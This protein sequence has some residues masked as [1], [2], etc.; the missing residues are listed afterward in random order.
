MERWLASSADEV[1]IGGVDAPGPGSDPVIAAVSWT[2]KAGGPW[3]DVRVLT[4][5]LCMRTFGIAGHNAY[6]EVITTFDELLPGHKQ[7]W[8][9]LFV[10]EPV[11]YVTVLAPNLMCRED[12]VLYFHAVRLIELGEEPCTVFPCVHASLLGARHWEWT[13]ACDARVTAEMNGE[14]WPMGR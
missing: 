10:D 7:V 1:P 5:E 6:G 8:I 13:T 14:I 3:L 9:R 11:E 12:A 4:R 2:R